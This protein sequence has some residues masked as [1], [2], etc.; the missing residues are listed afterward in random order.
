MGKGGGDLLAVTIPEACDA[1]L[2]SQ[3]EAFSRLQ[4]PVLTPFH[5]LVSDE[6]FR[7]VY[8]I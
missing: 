6:R 5:S 1:P 8:L 3:R 7:N 2:R 4:E